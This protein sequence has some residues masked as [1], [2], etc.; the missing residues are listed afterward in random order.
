MDTFSF[1]LR[2]AVW[3]L[4]GILLVSTFFA[5]NGVLM[6]VCFLLVVFCALGY[7]WFDNEKFGELL[8]NFA[9]FSTEKE[10]EVYDPSRVHQSFRETYYHKATPKDLVRLLE[11]LR[12]Q[13]THVRIFYGDPVTGLEERH[14]D[15][16]V[17]C[18]SGALQIPLLSRNGQQ[19]GTPLLDHHIVQ[20]VDIERD[21]ILYQHPTYHQVGDLET[22]DDVEAADDMD[23]ADEVKAADEVTIPDEADPVD[24]VDDDLE[25]DFVF[26]EGPVR[27]HI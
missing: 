25:H 16:Y 26:F 7:R 19:G 9:V 4:A 22:T 12:Q 27:R 3:I 20:I 24:G 1:L 13:Y 17:N 23:A 14:V 18:S 15:G 2:R 8:S 11:D 21:F 6:F 5:K 10:S